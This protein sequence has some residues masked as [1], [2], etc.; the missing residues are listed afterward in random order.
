[1]A[2]KPIMKELVNTKLASGY[3]GWIYCGH[4]DENI[5][6]LCYVTYDNIKFSYRCK[7]G[8]SGYMRIG[9]GDVGD[10][11]SSDNKLV[12][13]RNRLCCPN[14]QS[15]LLTILDKKLISYQCKIDCVCCKTKYKEVKIL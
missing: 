1:M 12:P 2:R 7:C 9:F 8:E 13:V 6:Y 11:T 10:A 15:S 5:G 3:G 14:D 4:C